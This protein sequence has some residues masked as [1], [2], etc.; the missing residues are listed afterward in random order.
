MKVSVVIPVYNT[1]KYLKRCIDSVISQSYNNLEILIVDDGSTDGSSSICDSIA[2]SDSRVKVIHQINGGLSAARNAGINSS[3]GDYICFL[4]S[5]DYYC[6]DIIK[7]AVNEAENGCD[8][9]IWG[10]IAKFDDN[11]AD[12]KI[13]AQD[14]FKFI[15]GENCFTGEITSALGYAWNKLYN[16]DKLK[17]QTDGFEKGLWMIEDIEFNSRFFPVC[18]SVCVLNTVGTVYMQY[19]TQ[20][21]GK[22]YSDELFNQK[23]RASL[24]WQTVLE[25]L[26][27]KKD[28]TDEYVLSLKFSSA[29]SVVRAICAD[30][31]LTHDEKISKV[32]ELLNNKKAIELLHQAKVNSKIKNFF[33]FLY[34]KKL[35]GICVTIYTIRYRR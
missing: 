4:D 2:E 32:K 30:K 24:C 33:L 19:A 16:A 22:K 15:K 29:D 13:Y 34:R 11:S 25:T 5:D 27:F 14:Y 18:N 31:K 9:V 8:C 12:D 17:N 26:E 10:Y 28:K 1:E 6:P 7:Q 20:T 23:L 3:T 35:A 21:L